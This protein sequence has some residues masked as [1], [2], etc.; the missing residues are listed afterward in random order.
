MRQHI[1]LAATALWLLL[2]MA[3]GLVV[4][5]AWRAQAGCLLAAAIAAYPL[6]D[7][8]LLG[9]DASSGTEPPYESFIRGLEEEW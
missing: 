4:G 6:W 3:T 9:S 5:L 7:R 2:A 1:S 8:R